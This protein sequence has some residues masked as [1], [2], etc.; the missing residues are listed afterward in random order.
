MK[1]PPL[2]FHPTVRRDVIPELVGRK[3]RGD[4]FSA[5]DQW[6][7]ELLQTIS[8]HRPEFLTV[9]KLRHV[10]S[11]HSEYILI[12]FTNKT[13]TSCAAPPY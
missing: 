1:H 4:P 8:P 2:R 3:L 6:P 12:T 5:S 13:L 10:G 11:V 9:R 7:R